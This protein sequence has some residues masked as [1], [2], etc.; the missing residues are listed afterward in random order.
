M[1]TAPKN[2]MASS[3]LSTLREYTREVFTF[4]G[5]GLALLVYADFKDVVR[6]T[7]T[8]SAQT[9][10]ILNS[11]DARLTRLEDYHARAEA[12]KEGQQ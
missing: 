2:T 6:T 10:Q 4:G 8:T 1:T 5:F 11:M 7:T 3:Y 12:R 9:A